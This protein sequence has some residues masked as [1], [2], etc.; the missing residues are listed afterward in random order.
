M[1]RSCSGAARVAELQVA[2][3]V[4]GHPLERLQLRAIVAEIRRRHRE[5]RRRRRLLEQAH[6]AIRLAIG[7]RRDQHAFDGAEDSGVWRRSPVPA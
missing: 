5:V 1:P 2:A 4:C 7:Q 6:Q 3:K